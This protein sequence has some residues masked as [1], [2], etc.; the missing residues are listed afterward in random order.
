MNPMQDHQSLAPG[1]KFGLTIYMADDILVYIEIF[2]SD[3]LH[4]TKRSLPCPGYGKFASLDDEVLTDYPVE[5]DINLVIS[6]FIQLC[7]TESPK[8]PQ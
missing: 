1:L 4:H 3:Y 8:S 5:T 2:W 7:M 6:I